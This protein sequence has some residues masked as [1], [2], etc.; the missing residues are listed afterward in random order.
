MDFQNKKKVA[1][2]IRRQKC[3]TLKS[4][5]TANSK[6]LAKLFIKEQNGK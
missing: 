5:G 1:K 6:L 4:K 3:Q 2:N